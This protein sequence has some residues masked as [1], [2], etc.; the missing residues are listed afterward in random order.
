MNT[1]SDI[2][3]KTRDDAV[4]IFLKGLEAVAPD[5]AVRRF[6]RRDDNR[7]TIGNQSFQLNAY[8]NIFVVGAGKA[9]APMAATL[10]ELLEDALTGGVITVKYG[11]TVT[12]SKIQTVEAG[13]PVPDAN[14]E[15]GSEKILDMANAAGE[16]D[17][18]ICL[19]SGGGSALLPK[20][21]PG[22]SLADKQETT[23]ILLACGATIHEINMLRKHLSMIKGG[24]LAIA[25]APATVVSMILSDV[26]GDDLDAIA[27]GPT[28]PDK[29]TFVDCLHIIEK[30]AIS[31]QLPKSVRDHLI[32]GS[33]GRVPETP[34]PSDPVFEKTSNVVIGSNIEAL[35]AAE[36]EA[37]RRGYTAMVLSSMIEG[38]TCDVARVHAAI[39]REMMATGHP[40]KPPACILSGGETTVTLK[41]SGL[42]GRNQQFA[43]CAVADM[44]GT[45]PAVILSGGTDG[46]DGPTDAAGAIVDNTTLERAAASR[47]SVAEHLANNDSYHFFKALGDLLITGPTNTNVMDLRILLIPG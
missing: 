40:L 14:G 46:N 33:N 26:V 3:R 28:V 41:G 23:R 22:V 1:P 39:A 32:K 18:L 24:R 37:V 11:H 35:L 20:A 47:V 43:L 21:A 12:L 7:L 4:S 17:L 31:D 15:L 36:K 38:E 5:T 25:A 6:C 45:R 44:A 34:K 13:H 8:R 16:R 29:S 30:Y 2:L 9:T 10:E 19:I 27:S 42:G